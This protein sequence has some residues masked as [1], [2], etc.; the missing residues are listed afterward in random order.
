MV[1]NSGRLMPRLSTRY[2]GIF[3]YFS[4]SRCQSDCDSGG[5]T[6]ITGCHSTI[7]SPDSVTRVAPPTSTMRKIRP[8]T[9]SSHSRIL[10]KC[11]RDAETGSMD[12]D[13]DA[14]DAAKLAK[15]AVRHNAAT[16]PGRE[17]QSCAQPPFRTTIY[18][19]TEP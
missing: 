2:C 5:D 12:R 19:A 4:N 10:C 14:A 13:A 8:A 9:A 7:E 17:H 6:P 15:L 16:S 18:A 1:L 3:W 11:P